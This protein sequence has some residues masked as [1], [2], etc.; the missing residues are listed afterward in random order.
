MLAETARGAHELGR[1][2][3]QFSP[4][5]RLNSILIGGQAQHL[6]P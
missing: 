4:A 2:F 5:L 1:E 6:F 3:N